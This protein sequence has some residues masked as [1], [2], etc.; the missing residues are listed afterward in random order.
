MY[1]ARRTVPKLGFA[2]LALQSSIAGADVYKCA[3][4]GGIPVYQ[5]MPCGQAKEL[6]NFQMDPPEITILPAPR[7]P[8]NAPS[9]IREAPAK[10]AKADKD[11]ARPGK[12]AGLVGD[13]AER[14][15][16][17]LGMSEAEVLAKLGHPDMTVGNKNAAAPRWTYLPAPGDPE[18]VT[19]LSFAKGTLVD[20]ERKVVKK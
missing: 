14:M 15:H 13:A 8:N 3:G 17:R 20:I 10:N 11:A 7:G 2:V 19:T 18:T 6:R 9:A 1:P 4:E 5:E 16:V 12:A